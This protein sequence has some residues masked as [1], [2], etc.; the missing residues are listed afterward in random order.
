MPF[1]LF[2]RDIPIIG[3]SFKM[4]AGWL[5]LAQLPFPFLLM[6]YERCVVLALLHHSFEFAG[7][8]F[9]DLAGIG[10]RG[11]R[12]QFIQTDD[13]VAVTIAGRPDLPD[14]F[15]RESGMG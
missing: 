3:N 1:D 11:Q 2:I 9:V 5:E 13:R 10:K 4:P 15:L 6:E 7:S 8:A 14:R 12:T